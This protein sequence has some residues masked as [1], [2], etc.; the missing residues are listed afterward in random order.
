ML[1]KKDNSN[2]YEFL[3]LKKAICEKLGFSIK[4]T[5]DCIKLHELILDADVGYISVTTLYRIFLNSSKTKPYQSTINILYKYLGFHNQEEFI[6]YV[7]NQTNQSK[8]QFKE[9]DN[10]KNELLYH[11]INLNAFKPIDNLFDTLKEAQVFER[12]KNAFHLFDCLQKINNPVPFFKR[13]SKNEFVRE[14]FYEEGFDP[15]FRIKGYE[16]GFEFYLDGINPYNNYKDLQDYIFGKTVLFRHCFLQKDY[17]N[18]LKLGDQLYCQLSISQN[19]LDKI[20]IFPR[21]RFMVYKLWFLLISQ[22]HRSI[23]NDYL[24]GMLSYCKKNYSITDSDKN[25]ILYYNFVE[26]LLFVPRSDIYHDRLKEIFLTEFN[27]LPKSLVHK[28]IK[29]S[30]PYFEPNG[31]LLIRPL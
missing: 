31:L 29:H 14:E 28:H 30:L 26:G 25:K 9:R 18:A 5:P 23:V 1:P 8:I 4:T 11:C 21:M 27:S 13:F 15:A 19:E 16:V 22:S 12:K 3:Q 20:N 6:S 10:F 2:S 7:D 17:V 24:E